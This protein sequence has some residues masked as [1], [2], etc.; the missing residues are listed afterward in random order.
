MMKRPFACVGYTCLFTL[1]AAVFFLQ[2]WAPF[3]AVA[4]AALGA[5]SLL[6]PALRRGRVIPVFLLTAAFA[7]VWYSIWLPDYRKDQG[8]ADS[9]Y[10]V[11]G[12][13]TEEPERSG[14]KFAY[15]MQ[16]DSA[17]NLQGEEVH[18]SGK[19]R[20]NCVN[21]LT[22]EVGDRVSGK[23]YAYLPGQDF[24]PYYAARGIYLSSF[25]YEYDRVKI[26][27]AQ[28]PTWKSILLG[29]RSGLEDTL[30]TLLP[31]REAGLISGIVLGDRDKVPE[32]VSDSFR[33]AGASHLLAVS[34][35]HLSVLAQF[36]MELLALLRLPKKLTCLLLM[37][38]IVGFMALTGFS[39][40][41]LR[42]GIMFL[43]YLIAQ[44]V[45]R[46]SDG[47]NSLGIAVMILCLL[48]PFSAGDT[49][50]LLSFSATLGIL[51]FHRRIM[52]KL[53]SHF[54]GRLEASRWRRPV[55]LVL[56]SV[57]LTV[58]ASVF[59]IPI[60]IF[61]FG[62]VSLVAPLSNLLMVI[63]GSFLLITGALTVMAGAFSP[64]AALP[65][66]FLA[67]MLARYEIGI[68]QLLSQIPF[69]LVD[70]SQPY[71]RIWFAGV[72][73]LAGV[74]LLCSQRRRLF[75][76]TV[77]FSLFLLVIGMLG[78]YI[79][80]YDAITI[81]GFYSDGE[82][83]VMAERSGRGVLL[84]GDAPDS[85]TLAQHGITAIEFDGAET[86][87][88]ELWGGQL[89]ILKK[90]EDFCTFTVWG[91]TMMVCGEESNLSALDDSW[92]TPAVLWMDGIPEEEGALSPGLAIALTTEARQASYSRVMYTDGEIQLQCT[93]DGEIQPERR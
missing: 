68:S 28:G 90:G 77:I 87:D 14:D 1:A 33:M 40:S 88:T 65:L 72:L 80:Y 67:G 44:L 6:L 75:P 78:D 48:N 49:G 42:S 64:V 39:Y 61:A 12:T 19:L 82:Y 24:Q 63:P 26:E 29:F 86:Q 79:L 25:L 34:G 30:Y 47:L 62:T 53:E 50:L 3:L 5:L 89:R 76:L 17:S 15:V 38:V 21:A 69:A 4:A 74:T 8:L 11:S 46:K 55:L 36:L 43:L 10:L 91:T 2:E 31:E 22:V 23:I 60:G 27:K 84:W 93:P 13:I 18:F 41:V 35:L 51:L 85:Y 81:M 37:P 73:I 9:D 52:K 7:L 71:V 70:A 66:A 58:S 32:D 57:V 20:F 59:T 56:E 83:H 54:P 16:V 45:D 92:S